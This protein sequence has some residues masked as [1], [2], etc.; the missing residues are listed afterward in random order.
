MAGLRRPSIKK[1]FVPPVDRLLLFAILTI[2]LPRQC[3]QLPWFLPHQ[4]KT[5]LPGQILFLRAGVWK[6]YF[7]PPVDRFFQVAILA[8]NLPRQ[9]EQLPWLLPHQGKRLSPGQIIFLATTV[10]RWHKCRLSLRESSDTF[11][12]RKATNREVILRPILGQHFL[13]RSP[14]RFADVPRHGVTGQP[15]AKL[16][17]SG[18]D[19]RKSALRTWRRRP[20]GLNGAN[21]RELPASRPAA[22]KAPASDSTRSFTSRSKTD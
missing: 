12:E 14:P 6:K 2:D 8:V 16:R 10:R 3:E 1:K 11:A 17:Q 19:R 20:P 4:G 21:S 9:C 18:P 7:F 13:A 5:L 15:G 22:R